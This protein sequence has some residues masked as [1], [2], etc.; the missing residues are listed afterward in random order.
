MSS[1]D[2]AAS[3]ITAPYK[4][5]NNYRPIGALE[6]LHSINVFDS[7]LKLLSRMSSINSDEGIG[8]SGSKRKYSYD[9]SDS[10]S[11]YP[12][13]TQLDE[14]EAIAVLTNIDGEK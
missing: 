9:S 12:K 10:A 7:D 6:R 8:N 3:S 11:K 1:F 4:G 13:A 14:L 2:K 5:E